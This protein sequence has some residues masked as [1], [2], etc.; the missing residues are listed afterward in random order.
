MVRSGESTP[1]TIWQKAPDG[2]RHKRAAA[3]PEHDLHLLPLDRDLLDQRSNQIPL[4]RPISRLQLSRHRRRERFQ[5]SDKQPEFRPER[6]FVRQLV[7]VGL[8]LGQSLSQ[9]RAARFAFAL[10]DQ[11]FGITRN[12]TRQAVAQPGDLRLRRGSTARL[13]GRCR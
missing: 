4:A 5:P 7:R 2:A 11:A 6:G 12:Q 8:Q 9:A 10:R 1:P 3:H 13:C